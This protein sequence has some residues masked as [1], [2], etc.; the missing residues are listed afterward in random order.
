MNMY[1]FDR[2]E[3]KLDCNEGSIVNGV[4]QGISFTFG[5]KNS[6][7]YIFLNEPLDRTKFIEKIYFYDEN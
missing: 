7:A 4:R 2:V 1:T 6:A 5:L 3:L